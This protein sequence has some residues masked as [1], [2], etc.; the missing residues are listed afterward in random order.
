ML[1]DLGL[2][3]ADFE[4]V[5]LLHVLERA[6]NPMTLLKE[7]RRHLAPGGKLLLQLP[8]PDCWPAL[9]LGGGWAGF[10]IPRRRF[11]FRPAGLG[12]LLSECGYE[13]IECHRLFGAEDALSLAASVAPSLHP[14]VHRI[15]NPDRS[16][17]T[18][19][20]NDLLFWTLAAAVSPLTLLEAISGSGGSLLVTARRLDD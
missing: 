9:L 20:A 4:A 5:T 17:L 19:A 8:N 14:A 10:D 6:A 3:G 2:G 11:L 1:A 13:L 15:L 12:R 16:L 7:F 18:R